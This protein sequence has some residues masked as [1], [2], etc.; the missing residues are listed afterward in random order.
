MFAQQILSSGAI[1]EPV[2]QLLVMKRLESRRQIFQL[3]GSIWMKRCRSSSHVVFSMWEDVATSYCTTTVS[4]LYPRVACLTI[5]RYHR[6]LQLQNLLC[7]VNEN[8]NII[9]NFN[10]ARSKLHQ[11]RHAKSKLIGSPFTS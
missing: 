8:S 1:S 6:N 7:T 4:L 3:F 2:S 10:V 9:N 11:Q 5:N